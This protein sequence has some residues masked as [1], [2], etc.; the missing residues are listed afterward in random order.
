M[1]WSYVHFTISVTFLTILHNK[2]LITLR[3]IVTI[4]VLLFQTFLTWRWAEL[5]SDNLHFWHPSWE[6]VLFSVKLCT[7]TLLLLLDMLTYWL[8]LW[9]QM[10]SFV[11]WFLHVCRTLYD[12]GLQFPLVMHSKMEQRFWNEH[13]W[14]ANLLWDTILGSKFHQW[15]K[16]FGWERVKML[17]GIELFGNSVYLHFWLCSGEPFL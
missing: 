10:V 3:I 16:C 1:L 14:L 17:L 7:L 8:L 15:Y 4:A 2:T 5:Q 13:C 11:E 6:V 9:R 12:L